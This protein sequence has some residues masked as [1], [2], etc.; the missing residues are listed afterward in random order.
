MAQLLQPKYASYLSSEQR[1]E[2]VRTVERAVEFHG[3]SDIAV[4][5]RHGPRLYSRFMGGL[6]ERVKAPPA[7]PPRRSRSNRKTSALATPELSQTSSR[8]ATQHNS[9]NHFEPLPA[10]TTTP[11]DHFAMPSEVDPTASASGSALGLTASEFFY[12]PLPFDRDLVESMQSLSSQ[13]EMHDAT[14]PGMDIHTYLVSSDPTDRGLFARVWMD[15]TNATGGLCSVPTMVGRRVIFAN[16][17]IWVHMYLLFFP[18]RAMSR[19]VSNC[20]H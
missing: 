1:A 4:D 15:E 3:S 10:R 11:F 20:I 16:C 19:L 2:I 7:N 6:L 9:A 12:S 8:P 14:L 17:L 5:D 13:S 18:F